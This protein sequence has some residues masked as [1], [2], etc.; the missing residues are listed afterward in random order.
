VS[1]AFGSYGLRLR[2][3]PPEALVP[4]PRSWPELELL[5]CVGEATHTADELGDDGAVVVYRDKGAVEI[6]RSPARATFTF[7]HR[8]GDGELLHPY[9]AAPAAIVNRWIGREPL[10][11]G[12][13]L[14]DESAWGVLAD[15][16][17]G[18]SSLLAAL[19][20]EG[21]AVLSD[22]LAVT[23]GE[24]VFAG[25]RAIDL[26][27]SAAGHLEAGEPLGLVGARERWRLSLAGVRPTGALAGWI[28]LSWGERVRMRRVSLD[29]RLIRLIGARAVVSEPDPRLLL[30]LA[31]FPAFELQRPRD[32]AALPETI[33]CLLATLEHPS[34]SDARGASSA[35]HAG[36][37]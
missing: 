34:R 30:R 16:E 20:R 37:A 36:E 8:L 13:L 2:G 12:A 32:W 31:S 1:S 29:E 4:A 3:L 25:P 11:G 26:R 9:L 14:L 22:D 18:K 21:R 10:H 17:G 28:F 7:P 5:R 33:S 24:V 27:A 6:T 15:Q 23:D 19:S 35:T